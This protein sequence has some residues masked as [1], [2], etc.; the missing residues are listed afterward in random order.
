MEVLV[1]DERWMVVIGDCMVNP[2][3]IVCGVEHL[4]LFFSI[5]T[6]TGVFI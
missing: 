6:M 4:W 2:L 3:M 5:L 1:I